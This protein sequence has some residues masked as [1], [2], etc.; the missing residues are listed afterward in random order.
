[1]YNFHEITKQ[2]SEG[3]TIK[4][5]TAK[6]GYLGEPFAITEITANYVCVKPMS[7]SLQRISDKDFAKVS[8]V[9]NAYI[10]GNFQRYKMRDITRFSKYIISIF[11]HIEK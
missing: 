1:M 2:L 4:N 10:N 6:S 8:E 7:A 9:W 5:W 11:H 3:Q